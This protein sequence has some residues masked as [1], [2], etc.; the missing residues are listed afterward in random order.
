MNVTYHKAASNEFSLKTVKTAYSSDRLNMGSAGLMHF[1][2]SAYQ[3]FIPPSSSESPLEE[4]I[5]VN[6]KVRGKI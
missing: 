5:Q 1:A 3:V 6:G 2:P 4:V